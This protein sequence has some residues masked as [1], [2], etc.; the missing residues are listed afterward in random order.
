MALPPEQ[1]SIKRRREEEP[2]ETLYIQS[3]L[4]QSKRRFTDFVFQ[5]V[6]ITSDGRQTSSPSPSPLST[7]QRTIRSPRSVSSFSVPRTRP[8]AAASEGLGVPLV[9][10]TSPGAEFRE[11]KRLAAARKEADE[12]F[13]RALHASP[14]PSPPSTTA[15]RE[16]GATASPK[17][18]DVS[19]NSTAASEDTAST[20]G[21]R[22][23]PLRRFQ[24]SR[25]STPMSLLRGSTGAG[26][27]KRKDGAGGV[28]VLVEKLR[29]TAHS[30]Q[31]SLVAEAALRADEPVRVEPAMTAETGAARA[32]KR[33]V[34]NKAERQWREQRKTAISAAKA[35]IS[36]VLEKEAQTQRQS[37]W[38][39]ESE[40]LA[41][42]FEQIA[43]E[44]EE[45]GVR[46]DEEER[47]E[48][49]GSAS[50]GGSAQVVLPKP[51]LKYQPRTP[52]THR[53]GPA[54]G[55][56]VEP[57]DES[58]DGEY[59]YDT[60]VRRPLGDGGPWLANPLVDLET[61]RGID[62]TRQDIGV[63]VITQ[64]DEEYWE[65]FVVDDE[66]DEDRWDSEDGD[67]NGSPSPN[68]TFL[69]AV[70]LTSVTSGK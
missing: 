40:R 20:G 67:S 14:A 34:V 3:E 26:V 35:H 55:T 58:D 56:A 24:I 61:G 66:D 15:T 32:R 59:V 5:R 38:D 7:A 25:A 57:D 52:N 39:D 6:Q 28:A 64:E 27:Q 33:P 42:E 9:R 17:P 51:P 65:H 22:E 13:K 4:H 70:K 23:T 49:N 50:G 31:A 48:G 54:A 62:A 43:L 8:A 46:G 47:P 21:G 68:G 11:E 37:N 30:R 41:R 63:I 1:I 2:P 69:P 19:A 36:E 53:A 60:Y 16:R 10:A 44:L 12:K 45:E 18:T 29:R